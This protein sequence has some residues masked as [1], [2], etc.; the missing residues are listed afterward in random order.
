MRFVDNSTLVLDCTVPV[1]VII[2]R[3]II[4]DVYGYRLS[5]NII[6]DLTCELRADEYT[7]RAGR[8][9]SREIA[10]RVAEETKSK[11]KQQ[12][13]REMNKQIYDYLELNYQVSRSG[14]D[15][16]L[17]QAKKARQ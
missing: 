13:Y 4:K 15:L 10:D 17:T 9:V 7:S 1:T 14:L 16:A 12:F 5:V 11:K 8:T 6:D 2:G 3:S